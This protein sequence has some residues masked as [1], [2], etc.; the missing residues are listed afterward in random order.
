MT[1]LTLVSYHL[2]PYVQRAAIALTEKEVP[3]E[4]TYVDLSNKPDWF[5]AL[6]PLGKVPLL[7]V[8][9]GEREAVIFESA[10]I[11]EYL[12][13]TQA[14]PLHPADPLERA[15]HRS[16]IEFGSSILSGIA[17]FYNAKKDEALNDEAA[18]LAGMFERIEVEINGPWFAG[19]AFSLVDAVF[20]PIFRYFDVFDRIADFGVLA[21]KRKT[22][23]WRAAL[24]E[25]P[26]VRNAV[27]PDYPD[28][29]M[30]FLRNRKS[31]L[32]R[33]IAG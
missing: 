6:S 23:A 27:A 4:R 26:S 17:R 8:T 9:Q 32:S 18:T 11:L 33:R 19:N 12:E 21:D 13:E 29:L 1:A 16:W 15:C 10:V 5:R 7:K 20:G 31:A 25:R 3:F 2:C 28:R 24:A 14:N 30:A 22:A